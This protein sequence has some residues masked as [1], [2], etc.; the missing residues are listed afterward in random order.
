MYRAGKTTSSP[1]SVRV[2]VDRPHRKALLAP[3]LTSRS[4]AEDRPVH[5]MVTGVSRET[6]RYGR[7]QLEGPLLEL[8]TGVVPADGR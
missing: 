7:K 1:S 2:S 4:T 8:Y 3:E 6:S 5:L